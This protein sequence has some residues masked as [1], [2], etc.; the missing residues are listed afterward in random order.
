MKQA[1]K[2]IRIVIDTNLFI[3]LLIGKRSVELREILVSPLFTI[4]V[5]QSLIEEIRIVANRP[6][7]SRCFNLNEVEAFLE[8]LRGISDAVEL[9]EI[10]ARCRDPKDDYLLELAMASKAEFLLTGD[11]DLLEMKRVGFCRILTVRD[12]LLLLQSQK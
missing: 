1:S 3:S 12:F 2:P 11:D 8:F 6:K 7:F 5:S 4:V 10:P 9:K